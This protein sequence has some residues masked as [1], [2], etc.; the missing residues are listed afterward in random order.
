M[1]AKTAACVAW[2][3]V[4][5]AASLA[6]GQGFQ[7]G[8][9]GSVKDANGVVPGV[10]VTL[11]NESTNLKRSVATNERGEYSFAA[12][13]PGT[14][15]VRAALAGF[16]TVDRRGVRIGTQQFFVLDI[17]LEVGAIEENITV[18]G[19]SPVIETGNASQGTIL[20]SAALET[21]PA[22]GRNAF[23]IGTTVPTVV[24]TGDTQFNRQQDQTNA[25]LLSLG[26]GTRRGNNYTLDGVPITDLR[27][28]ASAN[29][30]IEA[31]EDVKVQVH[32]YDAEMGRTGGGVFN[33]TL[34]SGTNSFHGTGFYQT[35]PIWAEKNNY[36]SDIGRQVAVSN[37]DVSTAQKLDKP[38]NPY[39]LGGGGFGG[40]IK[41]DRTFFWFA[42]EDYTDVQT[43]NASE[44]MPTPAERLGDF[45][46]LTNSSGQRVTIYDPISRLAFPNNNINQFFNPATGTWTPGNRINP[47][48]AAM[49]KYLPLPDSNI[50]NG[51]ANYNRTSLIKSSWTSEYT[52]KVEHKLSD[53]LTLSGFYL[54]NR[55]NEPCANYFGSADQTEP[56]RFADPNDY[57][58][59]RRP[60]IVA[61]NAT[62]VLN[63]N[64]VMA[65]RFGITRFPDSS[66]LSIPF[67]PSTLPFSAS[68]A[69]LIAFQKFPD[70][71]IR[72]YDSFAGQTLGA[73]GPNSTPGPP[74]SINWKSTAVNGNYSRFAGTHT[75]KF[76]ADF[77]KIG[78]DYLSPGSGAG[79]FDFD[80]DTTSSNG[81]TGGTT[82][83]SAFASFLLGY[84]SALSSRQSF[85]TLATPVNIFA[86]YYGGYAQD[87]WR[88]SSKLTVNYGLR[89]EHETGMA[90][91]SNNF[92]V[93][94]D[95]AAKN[96]LS[97]ITIPADPVAGTPAR[98]VSG[99]LMY[100]GVDGNPTTQGNPPK[101]KWSPRLGT[102]YSLD[103]KTVVRGGYGIYWAPYNYPIPS[104]STNNYGQVGFTQ[105]TI[106]PQTSGVPTVSLTDPFPAGVV[107]PLGNSLR[108]LT[109]AGT[110]ISYVDQN[111]TAPRVQ[112]YSVDFERQIGGDQAISI[113]YVGSR[114]DHL[115]LGGSA[116]VAVNI[117]QLDPAYLSLGSALNAQVANPFF[118]NPAFAGTS[119]FSSPTLARGQLLRPYPQFQNINARHVLEG[120]S[121]YNAAVFE[122]KKRLTH[123]LGGSVSYTYS[124]LKDNQ[125]GEGNFYS[126][127]GTN[128]LNNYNYIPSYPACTSTNFAACY[129]PDADFTTSLL[130]VP[131]RVI[132]APIVQLPFGSGQ[133]WGSKSTLADWIAGGWTL[134]TQINLQSGFP[135]SV[136]QND[137]TGT[138][139]GVQRPN[140]VPGVP[141]DTP[142]DLADRLASADHPT[143][144][145]INPAAF[146]TAAPF[147]F[148]NAPRTITDLRTPPQYNVDA[149]FIKGFRLGGA[150][151]A[152]FKIEMLNLFNRV[153][154]R[155][156]NGRNTVGNSNFGQTAVQ[157]GF[158]RI[159]QMTFRFSF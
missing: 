87:D 139:S 90:E 75:F 17:T 23:M 100:A 57:L 113:S 49:L 47:V 82:D 16:K 54:Y 126:A 156:L 96:A 97:S 112:Q 121:R 18:T 147:T 91:Q 41:K 35:R 38:N 19:A 128:P 95:P 28:R 22:P 29:P 78:V 136:Q 77:R 119:F 103:S 84:P 99:G 79:Y 39:N 76:G 131:H 137:N 32:T 145:W 142:G 67:D 30:T 43:R 65:L 14:Y 80:K 135:L 109:G 10:E 59:V 36:F 155:A 2:L 46:G 134:S 123:N 115:S 107:Q 152:Q 149:V 55:S 132:I 3:L 141:L 4:G 129:N 66:T 74:T 8:L 72:G 148:G 92:T 122:W 63:D 88:V 130:D 116:D 51:S 53:K 85:L 42:A 12:V 25:S 73:M 93:G 125:I 83:G 105:N 1:R 114:G 70:V 27:N 7:G 69:K 143:A 58:L 50:D 120:K 118:N 133:R 31:L 44:L 24:P 48:A 15:T 124:N 140:L 104:S 98:T 20:D 138:F 108:T 64:S 56:T 52:M 151:S 102:V 11:T 26:G 106:L 33:S 81:G 6:S 37:G 62:N 94:F 159:T 153:N 71:R 146:T 40:P 110:A 68:Y 127:G 34:R 13:E 111:S 150:K 89:L 5:A 45:S 86:Y 117:N 61:V 144:T 157:A 101:V 9:R 60:K 21:L 158:M 154:T